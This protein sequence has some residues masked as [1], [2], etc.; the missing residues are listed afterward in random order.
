MEIEDNKITN[1]TEDAEAAKNGKKPGPFAGMKDRK[2]LKVKIKF[3]FEVLERY[4]DV[5]QMVLFTLFSMLCGL[6]QFV[7][8]FLL[9]YTLVY[10][11]ALKP[12]FQR[13]SVGS[14]YLF[15]YDSIAQGIG[16]LAGAIVGNTLTF[17]L[18]RKKTFRATNNVAV[19]ATMYA[20]LAVFITLL[21]TLVGGWVSTPCLE[22]AGDLAKNNGFIHFLCDFA[23][24]AC[25]GIMALITSF[26]GNK[27]LV[28]R[29][30]GKG[31][32]KSAAETAASAE[33]GAE[34]EEG[35]KSAD[36]E[37]GESEKPSSL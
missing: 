9:Q 1:K 35:G 2:G 32:E 8:Q 18:N 21:Q 6:G 16:F 37:T 4:P 24:L 34:T 27:F 7:T 19:A 17:I 11:P 20:I 33:P 25:G 28:M 10:I 29:S 15:N 3:F 31:A 26:L 14:L 22:A 12:P 30:W 13:V 36:A 23:G 5:R